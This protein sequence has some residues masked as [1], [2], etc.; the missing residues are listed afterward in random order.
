MSEL[1][2]IIRPLI[3]LEDVSGGWFGK[4]QER[5]FKGEQ[6][7][8]VI[9]KLNYNEEQAEQ[10]SQE[11]VEQEILYNVNGGGFAPDQYFR[12]RE[13]RMDIARNTIHNW[14]KE[15]RMVHLIIPNLQTLIN[16]I[17]HEYRDNLGAARTSPQFENFLQAISELQRVEIKSLSKVNKIAFFINIY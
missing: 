3:Q 17:V 15:V 13:D 11:L 4:K 5:V 9:Q 2:K 10:F 6:L 7:L 8:Q 14:T 16:Q 1:Y 12:F